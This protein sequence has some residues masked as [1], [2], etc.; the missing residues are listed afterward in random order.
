MSWSDPI[1]DML[2]RIRNAH[3][4]GLEAVEMPH[5]KMKGEIVRVLKREGYVGDYVVE[6]SVKKTLRIFLKYGS[7]GEPAIRGLKR[8]SHA[9]R[10]QYVPSAGV[11]RVLGGMGVAVLTTSQGVLSDKDARKRGIG[12]ELICSVW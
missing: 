7:D 8:T 2:T 10:R 6:G 12:G 5:S 11:P 9:G 4:A 1:A 3:G